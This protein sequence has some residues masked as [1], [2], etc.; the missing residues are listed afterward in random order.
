MKN[1]KGIDLYN[2]YQS[3]KKN[4]EV[5]EEFPTFKVWKEQNGLGEEVTATSDKKST[6]K[7]TKKTAA[8][9][10][11]KSTAKKD[12]KKTEK[13]TDEQKPKKVS[14]MSKCVD[15]YKEMMDGDK[16]P[17]RKEVIE[18]FIKEA[19]MTSAGAGTYWFNIKT[20]LSSNK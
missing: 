17:V 3:Q 8:K 4:A 7:T 2:E 13:S 1:L 19:D 14:K 9:K 20:K 15:I 6:P 12:P 11:E 5:T 10:T 18:R 16:H